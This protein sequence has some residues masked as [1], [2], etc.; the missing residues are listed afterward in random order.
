M[1]AIALP[2]RPRPRRRPAFL[3]L[4]AAVAVLLGPVARA[5]AVLWV[6]PIGSGAATL[7]ADGQVRL[8]TGGG[9]RLLATGVRGD[10]VRACHGDLLGIGADG[11]LRS[12]TGD[13][14]GPAVALHSRPACLDGGRIAVIGAGGRSVML[15]DPVLHPLAEVPL[16]ALPDADPTPVG[17]ALAVLSAPTQRY[18]HGILGDEIEA[19]AVTLLRQS[20]L[21][22]L[23]TL[24][25]RAPAVIEQRRVQQFPAAGPYGMLLT[26]STPS[27]GAGVQA[28]AV[29]GGA[30]RVVASADPI[31]SGERWLNLFAAVGDHAYAVRTP[32]IRGPLERYRLEGDR[33]IADRYALDIT[34]H[35]IGSRDLDLARLLPPP[36]GAGATDVLALPSFDLR[37]VHIVACGAQRCT[38]TLSLALDAPLSSDLAA[39][40][41][42]GRLIL[43]AGES[44]GTLQ[45]FTLDDGLWA[46]PT[47]H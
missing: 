38:T 11:R 26:V 7:A 39:A 46:P 31:G 29:E 40:W 14:V 44:D 16:D 36:P 24:T 17:D 35:R 9:D 15:L 30:L 22:T 47:A 8:Y 32:H 41:Q 34:N 20:D 42:G 43:Y 3:L 12:L 4:V 45:S 27:E 19:G 25:L 5:A 1:R 28:A 13:A 33:L 10:S 23:A 21:S 6:E 37:S 18:R 2:P